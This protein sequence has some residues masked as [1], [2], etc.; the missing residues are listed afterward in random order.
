MGQDFL[1]QARL[2]RRPH[3][4]WTIAR[5]SAWATWRKHARLR[6]MHVGKTLTPQ[7]ILVA[8][9]DALG[10]LVLTLPMLRALRKRFPKCTN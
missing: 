10:D 9:T 8:R 5:L 6:A 1:Y 2:P 7:K 3:T 4:G